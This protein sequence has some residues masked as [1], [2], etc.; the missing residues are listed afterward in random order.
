MYIIYIYKKRKKVRYA[1]G[2]LLY[3]SYKLDTNKHLKVSNRQHFQ[4]KTAYDC[5][6]R[7]HL[8][9][10][11]RVYRL[12]KKVVRDNTICDFRD[13]DLNFNR[14]FSFFNAFFQLLGKLKRN[15]KYNHQ[16]Y[17]QE[18]ISYILFFI[19]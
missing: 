2:Y 9:C 14:N 17:Q 10:Q 15:S 18:S 6:D 8:F 5:D 12:E 13:E 11:N 16:K 4:S 3:W 1:D 19:C 7:S